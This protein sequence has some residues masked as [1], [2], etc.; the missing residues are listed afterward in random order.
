MTP[1]P[2]TRE[3]AIA[4]RKRPSSP[5]PSESDNSPPYE[6]HSDFEAPNGTPKKPVKKK[7][8]VK[9]TATPAFKEDTSAKIPKLYRSEEG[10]TLFSA[11]WFREVTKR[12]DFWADFQKKVP[13]AIW[14]K[15]FKVGITV[16]LNGEGGKDV[17]SS[18]KPARKSANTSRKTTT[19]TILTQDAENIAS[20][21]PS[22]DVHITET[23]T[24]IPTT[25]TTTDESLE[26][27]TQNDPNANDEL[28]LKQATAAGET[29]ESTRIKPA[30]IPD[31]DD[32]MSRVIA[33]PNL[34]AEQRAQYIAIKEEQ[35]RIAKS[36]ELDNE[37][38]RQ[39]ERHQH[40]RTTKSEQEVVET[41]EVTAEA[42][43][44]EGAGVNGEADADGDMSVRA[45]EV[46]NGAP[47][48]VD[49]TKETNGE[50][51]DSSMDVRPEEVEKDVLDTIE[52]TKAVN[53]EA[54][55]DVAEPECSGAKVTK[56]RP[57]KLFSPKLF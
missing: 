13:K 35:V 26:A 54:A 24:A 11:K 15:R 17:P 29:Q 27:P 37:E 19:R 30:A 12:D 43:A 23:N 5:T 16:D 1:L 14:S 48:I 57:R 34:S 49:G 20:A 25:L 28:K 46:E 39:E 53:G 51:A 18:R 36:I 7:A 21:D 6:S 42:A 3:L 45:E 56:A 50:D 52:V 47:E 4:S 8:K 32:P 10:N 38:R 55:K 31:D 41:V 2:A 9:K 33:D 44:E 40:E 22:P